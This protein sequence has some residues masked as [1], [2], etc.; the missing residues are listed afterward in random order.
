MIKKTISYEDYNGNKRTE[1]FYFNLNKAEL[2]EM[3]LSKDGGMT[4][5]I[6]KIVAAQSAPELIAL[7]KEFILKSY[8][9][10][11]PDGKYFDKSQ[12]ISD[13]FTHTEAY[14][15]LFMEL[16][17]NTEAGTA[18]MKGIIPSDLVPKSN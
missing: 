11:S 6:E 17:N 13:R 14:S 8:G 3:E 12:A 4:Q 2:T 18:F 9:E 10:K 1:D 16:T 7:F 5:M 15:V